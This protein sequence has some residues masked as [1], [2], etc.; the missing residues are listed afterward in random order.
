MTGQSKVALKE[1]SA[2]VLLGVIRYRGNSLDRIT[3]LI[4]REDKE[5]RNVRDYRWQTDHSA[6]TDLIA[7]YP[8]YLCPS[9]PC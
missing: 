4:S 9:I 3:S 8:S 1:A 2:I 6:L 7:L 5:P